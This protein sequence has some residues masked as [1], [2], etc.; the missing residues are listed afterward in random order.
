VLAHA[1][2]SA[3]IPGDFLASRGLESGRQI[4]H[5]TAGQILHADVDVGA[6]ASDRIRQA[7]DIEERVRR[8]PIEALEPP[9]L[10]PGRSS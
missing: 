4:A 8:R 9:R 10:A 1:V 7:G 3:S 5:A 6:R 2:I